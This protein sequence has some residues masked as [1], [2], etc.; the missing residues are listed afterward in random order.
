MS[1]EGLSITFEGSSNVFYNVI[2]LTFVPIGVNTCT[3]RLQYAY[4][5]RPF[6]MKTMKYSLLLD[7]KYKFTANLR[8]KD[9]KITKIHHFVA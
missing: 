6:Y 7:D 3:Y 5:V 1:F 4:K 9:H 8:D 2:L